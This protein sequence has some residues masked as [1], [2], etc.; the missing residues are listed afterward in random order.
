MSAKAMSEVSAMSAAAQRGVIAA[1]ARFQPA[2]RSS[3]I[4]AASG[5]DD[6]AAATMMMEQPAEMVPAAAWGAVVVPTITA[7]AWSRSTGGLESAVGSRD[8]AA[9]TGA[10]AAAAAIAE[11]PNER[12]RGRDFLGNRQ[13]SGAEEACPRLS[14]RHRTHGDREQGD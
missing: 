4:A 9:A 8:I 13:R 1:T 14:E 2:G 3:D 6:V 10:V 11:K 7:A 12:N 5:F